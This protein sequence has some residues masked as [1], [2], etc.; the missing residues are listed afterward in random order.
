MACSD[1][2]GT[3]QERAVLTCSNIYLRSRVAELEAEVE[4]LRGCARELVRI[5]E[6]FGRLAGEKPRSEAE[7]PVALR[8]R[9]EGGL[10]EGDEALA[11]LK[12]QTKAVGDE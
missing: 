4:T 2:E 3:E 10:L 8:V 11:W 1:C 12:E 7:P 9:L 5:A 6:G